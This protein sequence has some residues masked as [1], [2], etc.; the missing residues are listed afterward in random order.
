MEFPGEKIIKKAL[1]FYLEHNQDRFCGCVG[2]CDIRVRL[3]PQ[4]AMF[5]YVE[6]VKEGELTHTPYYPERQ[7]AREALQ[8]VGPFNQLRLA[9]ADLL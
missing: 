8:G 4:E 6:S 1:V 5:Y 3:F 7:E 9:W 2:C